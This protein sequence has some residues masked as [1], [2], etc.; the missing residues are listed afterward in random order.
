M[1]KKP[2]TTPGRRTARPV[3]ATAKSS[4]KSTPVARSA[5]KPAK[6]AA[7]ARSAVKAPPKT[8]ARPVGKAAPARP[9][10][11][12]AARPALN[13]ASLAKKPATKSSGS[14]L[15][16][17]KAQPVKAAAKSAPAKPQAKKA[18]P[19]KAPAP[20][21]KPAPAPAPAPADPP[22]EEQIMG[23]VSGKFSSARSAG[24]G[25]SWLAGAKDAA[26]ARAAAAEETP[27]AAA[28][29]APEP[30]APV[31]EAAPAVVEEIPAPADESEAAAPEAEAE[32]LTVAPVVIESTDAPLV[33]E[34][35]TVVVTV[36]EPEAAPAGESGAEPEEVSGETAA[37]V[38]ALPEP[39]VPAR[40][41]VSD[42][43][44]DQ[45]EATAKAFQKA[46]AQ[47]GG[48]L[49]VQAVVFLAFCVLIKGGVPQ[50]GL[51]HYIVSAIPLFA[52]ILAAA[53]FFAYAASQ[54]VFDHLEAG[55]PELAAHR[56]AAHRPAHIILF[57]LAGVWF[58]IGATVWFL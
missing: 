58:F 39:I 56:K 6:G 26:P 3:P 35:E 20:K 38:S 2:T 40:A 54:R 7:V 29:P 21:A 8:A 46:G 33:V 37:P 52:I 31:A 15:P 44:E 55:R 50:T 47:M 18:A 19:V 25:F 49:T 16:P 42:P 9:A 41:A 48:W 17:L 30:P 11:K 45:E 57:V 12:P 43:A 1:A 27:V 5:A 51:P 22:T 28:D 23:A 13:K 34:E 24:G 4:V 32:V 14:K 10:P 36:I 53:A